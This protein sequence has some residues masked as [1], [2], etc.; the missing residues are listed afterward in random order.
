MTSEDKLIPS[1]WTQVLSGAA[2]GG[3]KYWSPFHRAWLPV[4]V[5]SGRPLL[6]YAAVIRRFT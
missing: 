5:N 4:T 6:Y 3:D 2:L 1:G